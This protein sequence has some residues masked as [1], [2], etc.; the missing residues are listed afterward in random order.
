[1]PRSHVQSKEPAGRSRSHSLCLQYIYLFISMFL[2]HEVSMCW[3]PQKKSIWTLS[4][5]KPVIQ[6]Y[7]RNPR[8]NFK[9]VR[10]PRLDADLAA[11]WVS[12]RIRQPDTRSWG[13]CEDLPL[14]PSKFP[15]RKPVYSHWWPGQ[16]PL[17][18]HKDTI[19][20]RKHMCW[21][22]SQSISFLICSNVSDYNIILSLERLTCSKILEYHGKDYLF[23]QFH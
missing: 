16:R 4:P 22:P 15:R 18:A 11:P 3:F 6:T 13:A 20:V 21:I 14:L 19:S 7:S 8:Q 5:V 12:C 9:V 17:V 10:A 23:A 1:M 2:C